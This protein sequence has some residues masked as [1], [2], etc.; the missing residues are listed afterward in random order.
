MDSFGDAADDP[1]DESADA[2]V[3]D[4]VGDVWG[5]DSV[6]VTVAGAVEVAAGDSSDVLHPATKNVATPTVAMTG[7][8]CRRC[9]T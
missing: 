5:A 2:V 4:C 6:T 1:I 9:T 3:L 8:A 7:R